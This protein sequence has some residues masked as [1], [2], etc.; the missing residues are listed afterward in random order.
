MEM[1]T[2]A[3]LWGKK[4]GI[5]ADQLGAVVTSRWRIAVV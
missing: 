3:V 5:L 4:G 1:L 2:L